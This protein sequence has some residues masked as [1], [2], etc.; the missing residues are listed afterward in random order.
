VAEA[1]AIADSTSEKE[2]L[3]VE[4]D[5]VEKLDRSLHITTYILYILT[6]KLLWRFI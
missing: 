1:V 5:A 2:A 4:M 6:N 3:E